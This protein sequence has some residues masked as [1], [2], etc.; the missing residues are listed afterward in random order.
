MSKPRRFDWL[1]RPQLADEDLPLS[2][3]A[4]FAEA[5]ARLPAVERSAL[6]LSE[7]GGLDTNEIAER[8]GTDPAVV[9]KLLVRARESVQTSLAGRGRGL[10]ALLPLQSWWHTGSAAPAVRAA[11]V[12]AAA[13][14]APAVLTGG[15]AADPPRATLAPAD[16]PQ[17]QVLPNARLPVAQPVRVRVATASATATATATE[18]A[19]AAAGGRASSVS[20]P[21]RRG[22]DEPALAEP[23]RQPVADRPP[24][25]AVPL[26]TS[27]T[28]AAEPQRAHATPALTALPD[29]PVVL[30]EPSAAPVELPKL[31]IAVPVTPPETPVLPP[32]PAVPPLPLP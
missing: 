12:V 9:R 1:F 15:A 4:R 29:P 31:P 14:V 5:L 8:L 22:D 28:P 25:A 20:G 3:E 6:A 26:P 16:R 10:T 19:R 11:G 30:L 2:A 13:I 27:P 18:P 21:A 7:I 23:A 17:V 24:T 32:L